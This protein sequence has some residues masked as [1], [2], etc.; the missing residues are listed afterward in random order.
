MKICEYRNCSK[1]IIGRPNKKFC[2]RNCKSCEKKYLSR[3]KNKVNNG[4]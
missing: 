4:K 3:E 2:N 1:I